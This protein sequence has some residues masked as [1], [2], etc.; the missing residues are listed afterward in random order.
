VNFRFLPRLAAVAFLVATTAQAQEPKIRTSLATQGE[1][2]IGQRATL[3]VELLAPGYFSGAPSFE[4][5]DPSGILLIPPT[6]SPILSTE[7]IDG[8]SYTVQRHELSVFSRRAGDQT[9][10]PFAVHFQFKRQPLDKESVPA[11]VKTTAVHFTTKAPPGAEN[12]A[13]IISARNL[14]VVESWQPEPQKAKAGDAFTRTIIFAAPDVPAMAFPPFS[15]G[16]IDGLGIYD[17]PPMVLDHSERGNLRGERRDT[18][19]YV[20][21]RPGQFVIPAARF[22]WWDL[23]AQKLQVIDFPSRTLD[24]AP[25][26]AMASAA[27]AKPGE[28]PRAWPSL[29]LLLLAA[30][31]FRGFLFVPSHWDRWI[32]PWRPVHL[33]PLNPGDGR[34]PS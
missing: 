34:P 19:T 30:A 25:N 32:A 4:L 8:V 3:V 18:I 26:P 28:W 6:G 7:E 2:W 12:L 1:I 16:K 27:A 29:L 17:K 33:S 21:Q 11:T 31:L 24:V 5:P 10:P 20:C 9:I 15:S 22:T 23:D 13:G 14:T